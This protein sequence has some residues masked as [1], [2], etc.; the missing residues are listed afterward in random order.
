MI[1]K[2]LDNIEPHFHTGGKWEKWYALYEAVDTGLY[3]IQVLQNQAL[4]YVMV[5]I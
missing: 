4:T 2:F 5:W 1:R 3:K